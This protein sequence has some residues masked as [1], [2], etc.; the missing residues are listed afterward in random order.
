MRIH[1]P[2]YNRE[3]WTR[4]RYFTKDMTRWMAGYLW[5]AKD[6]QDYYQHQRFTR[7]LLRH[8]GK[9]PINMVDAKRTILKD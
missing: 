6:R 2:R 1:L 3:S 5:S 7:F 9:H 8:E 4:P